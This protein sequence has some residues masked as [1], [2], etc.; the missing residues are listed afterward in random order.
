MIVLVECV[1]DLS[2]ESRW[3]RGILFCI[4]VLDDN[5]LLSV[6]VKDFFYAI[7]TLEVIQIV[8]KLK[9]KKRRKKMRKM[10]K[11]LS[12]LLTVGMVAAAF[13]GCGGNGKSDSGSAD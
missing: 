10:K 5:I 4:F 1:R 3:H 12:V 11:V 9:V 13:T 8:K 2:Y 7:N 6:I